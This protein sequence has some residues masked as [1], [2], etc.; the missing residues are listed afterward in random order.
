MVL[1]DIIPLCLT[2]M[3]A[4]CFGMAM[5]KSKLS[6]TTERYQ[7][8]RLVQLRDVCTQST[9]NEMGGGRLCA[10]LDDMT[11]YASHHVHRACSISL[12]FALEPRK[13]ASA[14]DRW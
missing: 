11:N 9:R 5:T 14:F 13:C 12:P 8:A 4:F 10:L 6:G 1:N 3:A 7:T 2:P